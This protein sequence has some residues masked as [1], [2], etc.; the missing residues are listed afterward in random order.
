MTKPDCFAFSAL[1]EAVKWFVF[2]SQIILT[3]NAHYFA[4][5]PFNTRLRS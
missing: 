1:E 2:K 3:L 5:L 4:T